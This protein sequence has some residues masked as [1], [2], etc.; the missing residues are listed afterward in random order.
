VAIY[1]LQCA[2]QMDTA[3]PR[4]QVVITPHFNNTGGIL[5]DSD[6]DALCEDLATALNAWDASNAQITVKAY[7]AQGTPPVEPVGS[8]IRNEGAVGSSTMPREIAICLSFY[9]Q[10]NQ[11]RYRGRLYVPA[12]IF[13]P[14]M[15]AR[16]S[17]TARDKVGTLAAIFADLGGV[18]IDWS[19]YS[20]VDDTARAVSHWWVDDEWDTVRSRGLRSTTRSLGTVSE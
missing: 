12:V 8:A 7:D 19:V 20:R 6:T 1:R 16:P 15:A 11:P 2:W 14:S 4:D 9:S 13:S 18:D 5:T 10:Q 3:F 17:V